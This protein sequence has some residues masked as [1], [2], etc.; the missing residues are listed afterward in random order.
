MFPCAPNQTE[1]HIPYNSD[2]ILA[3]ENALP[4]FNKDASKVLLSINVYTLVSYAMA[5][6]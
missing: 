5:L 3:L 4:L 2:F 1:N 6:C